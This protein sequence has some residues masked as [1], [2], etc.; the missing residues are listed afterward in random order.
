MSF[1]ILSSASRLDVKWVNAHSGDAL[2]HL[3]PHAN[4]YY[5]L[6][7]VVD[8]PVYLQIEKKR[9]TLQAGETYLLKPWEQHFGWKEIGEQARFF[10]TQFQVEPAMR[11]LDELSPATAESLLTGSQKDLRGAAANE[12]QLVLPLRGRSERR[13]ELAL[14]FEKMIAEMKRPR[15]YFRV[16]LLILL[17]TLLELIADDLLQQNEQELSAPAS[18]LLYRKIVNHLDESYLGPI[19]KQALE[20]AMNRKYEYIC[21]IFKKYSG[22]TMTSYLHAL[23]VQRAQF[24][25]Q[26]TTLTIA[27]VAEQVG[28]ED[29]YYFGKL[30]KKQTGITPM[31]FRNGGHPIEKV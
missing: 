14:H 22:T 5:Q 17:W 1:L 13:F 3:T 15:G 25:L 7:F 24:L 20:T 16:R 29:P 6:I 10:W 26:T 21:A 27:E 9:L 11:P 19:S 12:V 30:F 2:F 4:P 28:Y 8:G 18:F 31:K 23:R